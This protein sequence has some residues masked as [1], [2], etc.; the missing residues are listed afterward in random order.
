L[1]VIYA[2]GPDEKLCTS[3]ANATGVTRM[4]NKIIVDKTKAFKHIFSLL[5]IYNP[6]FIAFII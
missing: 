4:R 2:Y 1:F 5:S 3:S 6:S